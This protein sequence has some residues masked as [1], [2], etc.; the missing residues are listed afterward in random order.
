MAASL[1]V[2]RL[3]QL[4]FDMREEFTRE[5]KQSILKR[6]HSQGLAA[7]G[8]LD[9]VERLENRLSAVVGCEVDRRRSAPALRG[10]RG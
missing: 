8:G 9:A 10:V 2:E 3:R 7:M 4:L 5:M 6:D 1:S